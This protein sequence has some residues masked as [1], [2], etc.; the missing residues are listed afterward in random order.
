MPG[1]PIYAVLETIA[2]SLVTKPNLLLQ[3]SAGAG[4][5]TLVPLQLLST[6]LLRQRRPHP[7][8][9]EPPM[10]TTTTTPQQIVVVAPRRVAVRVR[11]LGLVYP[12]KQQCTL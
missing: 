5:T 6:M 12:S 2:Q 10:Q 8:E 1:L 4:K 3:A 9:E 11:S 7:K